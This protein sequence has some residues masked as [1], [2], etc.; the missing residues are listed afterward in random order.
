MKQIF[1][2]VLRVLKNYVI[3]NFVVVKHFTNTK[4]TQQI[5]KIFNKSFQVLVLS[6][7]YY[8]MFFLIGH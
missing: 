5:K 8:K 4:T 2:E 3:C 1:R 7:N 6:L